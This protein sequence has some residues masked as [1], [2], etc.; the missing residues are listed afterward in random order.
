MR[1]LDELS[2][3]FGCA[4]MALLCGCASTP[5]LALASGTTLRSPRQLPKASTK[6]SCGSYKGEKVGVV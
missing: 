4:L 6:T 5:S 2:L 3:A 1:Q